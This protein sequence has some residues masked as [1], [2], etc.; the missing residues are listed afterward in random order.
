MAKFT[1]EVLRTERARV[2]IEADAK[3][4]ALDLYD[5]DPD[6]YNEEHEFVATE[7]V[8]VCYGTIKEVGEEEDAGFDLKCPKCGETEEFSVSG[9]AAIIITGSKLEG[10]DF[11]WDKYAS[12]SCVKCGHDGEAHEFDK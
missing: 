6:K 1:M 11:D 7:D 8:Q 4:Q 2:T 10:T 5:A 9:D 12:M 3:S